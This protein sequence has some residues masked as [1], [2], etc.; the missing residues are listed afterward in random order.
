MRKAYSYKP[1]VV[2]DPNYN[3]VR[4]EEVEGGRV[5]GGEEGSGRSDRGPRQDPL[6]DDE[7]KIADD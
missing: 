2:P 3:V 6:M 7:M 5:A 4:A 1:V